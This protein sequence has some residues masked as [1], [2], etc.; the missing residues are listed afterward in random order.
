MGGVKLDCESAAEENLQLKRKEQHPNLTTK[1][2][3]RTLYVPWFC[4]VIGNKGP[5][6]PKI[7][8][9]NRLV[10]LAIYR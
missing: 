4:M 2:P 8:M 7:S 9:I 3:T 5:V 10:R 6:L 1:A